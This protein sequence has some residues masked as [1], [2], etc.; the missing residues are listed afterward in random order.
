MILLMIANS[1]EEWG[2]NSE[3]KQQN[4]VEA[5]PSRKNKLASIKWKAK[6]NLDL[7]WRWI[8]L[9]RNFEKQIKSW[10]S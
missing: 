1:L 6:K 4:I 10:K 5:K 9:S 2:T 7:S 3:W 8:Q